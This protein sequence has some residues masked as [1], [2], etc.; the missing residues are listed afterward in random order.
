VFVKDANH[1]TIVNACDYVHNMN[2]ASACSYTGHTVKYQ[3]MSMWI[4]PVILD[5]TFQRTVMFT[6]IMDN[7]RH[8]KNAI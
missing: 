3:F 8:Y 1:L 6:M 7:E 2:E 4:A 5:E